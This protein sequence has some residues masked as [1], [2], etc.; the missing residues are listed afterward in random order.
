MWRKQR[1][2]SLQRRRMES[3]ISRLAIPLDSTNE[4]AVSSAMAWLKENTTLDTD[5]PESLPSEAR[6]FIVKYCEL[7]SANG[8]VTSESIAGMSQSFDTKTL[9][10]S[11][12]EYANALLGAHLKSQVR[13][14][15]AV[16]KWESWG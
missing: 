7:L 10:Q 11:I 12:W 6:L 8:G 15:S 3:L 13:F 1:K 5:D 14:K 2:R 4:L 9:I 16:N